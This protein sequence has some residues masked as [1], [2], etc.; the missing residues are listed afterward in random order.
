MGESGSGPMDCGM[1]FSSASWL[2][3]KVGAT[4]GLLCFFLLFDIKLSLSVLHLMCSSK[5]ARL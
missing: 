2:G 5:E 4:E 3:E 1:T